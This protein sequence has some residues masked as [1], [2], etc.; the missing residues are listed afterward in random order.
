MAT[1]RVSNAVV[2]YE[3]PIERTTVRRE[4]DK[5]PSTI[6]RW[7][8]PIFLLGA[9]IVTWI[10]LFVTGMAGGEFSKISYPGKLAN[11]VT[12]FHVVILIW[13]I[14]LIVRKQAWIR[15]I[16]VAVM[17]FGAWLTLLLGYIILA[18]GPLWGL[19]FPGVLALI[20]SASAAYAL[21]RYSKV[22]QTLAHQV[23]SLPGLEQTIAE[24][25]RKLN[26]SSIEA[27]DAQEQSDARKS[28]HS[29][30][31]N[32]AVES[33]RAFTE[34]RK[35]LESSDAAKEQKTL[36]AELAKAKARL[37]EIPDLVQGTLAAI[38]KLKGSGAAPLQHKVDTLEAEFKQLKDTD[39]PDLQ[40][41]VD[42]L[43]RRVE[44]SQEKR[45]LDAA[46]ALNK[47]NS[48]LEQEARA[49]YEKAKKRQAEKTDEWKSQQRV[50]EK[51]TSQ[52]TDVSARQ[53]TLVQTQRLEWRDELVFA[54]PL[55]VIALL[56]YPA[57]YGWVAL[58]V[59]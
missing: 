36:D 58:E 21:T 13:P 6:M 34:A 2:P 41:K 37:E 7:V 59:F 54:L 39:I 55:A 46:K 33:S 15:L 5:P 28:E 43:K 11:I 17:V 1:R 3:E 24:E 57:W 50:T 12:V 45:D 26:L 40:K 48:K 20:L 23:Q 51:L 14:V 18:G 19:K 10:V 16:V 27:K 4:T 29:K 25:E 38:A 31:A 9:V 42:V 30:A 53:D 52:R 35:V 56:C 44:I 32:I 47:R 22:D 49:D 8:F